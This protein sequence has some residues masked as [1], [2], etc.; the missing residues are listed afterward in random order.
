PGQLGGAFQN[1]VLSAN[2]G[3]E[4]YNF[5]ERGLAAGYVSKKYLLASSPALNTAAPE[6]TSAFLAIAALC[7]SGLLTGRKRK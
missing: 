3:G 2:I 7:G 4:F 1:M 5:G 6:P